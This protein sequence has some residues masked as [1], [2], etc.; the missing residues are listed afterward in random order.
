MKIVNAALVAACLLVGSTGALAQGREDVALRISASGVN[1]SDPVSVNAF[2]NRVA[3]EIAVVCNPGDRLNAD[4]TPDFQCRRELTA[5]A[6]P[7]ISTLASKAT[8]TV[9]KN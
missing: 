3:R 2:R 1:F 6:E 8:V 5:T 7:A 9:A 4:F